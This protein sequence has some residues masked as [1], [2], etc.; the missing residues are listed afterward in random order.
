MIS[1]PGDPTTNGVEDETAGGWDLGV[2]TSGVRNIRSWLDV[3]GYLR[4]LNPEHSHTVHR[5]QIHY[6]SVSGSG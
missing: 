1:P 3:G 2:P 5:D 6:G 4:L